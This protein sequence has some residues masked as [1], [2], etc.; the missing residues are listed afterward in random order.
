MSTSADTRLMREAGRDDGPRWRSSKPETRIGCSSSS[1]LSDAER[2]GDEAGDADGGEGAGV[3]RPEHDE[4]HE[5]VPEVG[6][7]GD[8]AEVDDAMRVESSAL[9]DAA[10]GGLERDDEHARS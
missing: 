6:A 7:V 5:P 10:V 3:E 2:G 1:K 8:L 4:D 9:D